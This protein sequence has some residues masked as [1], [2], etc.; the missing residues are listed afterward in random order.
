MGEYLK[1][2]MEA[3]KD[4]YI[5]KK[6]VEDA[7]KSQTPKEPHQ[8]TERENQH[9]A[10]QQKKAEFRKRVVD[11]MMRDQLLAQERTRLHVELLSI[12]AEALKDFDIEE[13]ADHWMN[14]C[15]YGNLQ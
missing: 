12:Q 1:K 5:T 7:I 15:D 13:I 9:L 3:A 4:Y 14:Y 8:P 2:A 11:G 6:A 10:K